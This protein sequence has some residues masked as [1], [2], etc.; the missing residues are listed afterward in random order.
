MIRSEASSVALLV[1]LVLVQVRDRALRSPKRTGFGVGACASTEYCL[2][3]TV[4]NSAPERPVARQEI[5]VRSVQRE[6][7]HDP[8]EVAVFCSLPPT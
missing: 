8:A 7:E 4:A 1:G 2:P 6:V 3:S 5:P